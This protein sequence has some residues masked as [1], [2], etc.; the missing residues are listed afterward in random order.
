MKLKNFFAYN[1]VAVLFLMSSC[2]GINELHDAYLQHGETIYTGRVDSAVAL[3][4]NKRV[5]LRYWVSDIKA[6][7]LQVYWLSRT[8]SVLLDIPVKPESEPVEV[9]ISDLPEGSLYFELFTMNKDLINKSIAYNL[10]GNVYGDK[11]QATLLN[12]TIKTKVFDPLTGKLT[13]NWLGTVEKSVGCDVEYTDINGATV[14]IRVPITENTTVLTDVA[15]D[16]KYRTL[17]LPE[18]TA[19]DTFYTEFKSVS[20]N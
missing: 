19:L 20:L 6:A 17:F 9:Y 2:G 7:K 8:D 10:G 5:L 16:V 11:Y 1:F 3:A 12:R 13:I 15:G 18:E 4:G 14:T